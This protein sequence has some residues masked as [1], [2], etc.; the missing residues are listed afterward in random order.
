MNKTGLVYHEDYLYHKTGNLHAECPARLISIINH[1]KTIGFYDQLHPITPVEA[2]RFWLEQIHRSN[3]ISSVETACQNGLS[4]LDADTDISK[5]S[6]RVA[7]LA[8]GGTLAAI[9]KVMDGTIKN[10]FCAI[11]PPGHHATK[12]QAM[13]FCLFNNVAIAARYIQQKYNLSKILIVDWDVHH[14]NGTQDSFYHDPSVFYFSIHQWPH[15]PGTGH[16]L[17]SGYGLGIGYTLNIPLK[18]GADD[19]VY[20]EAFI[21]QLLPAAIKFAPDFILISAGFDAH[22][23]DPLSDM[24]LTEQ[25]F[26]SLTKIICD[27]AAQTCGGRLISILEGGYNLA[28][29]ASSV[30]FHIK[31]LLEG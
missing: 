17:E 14:G 30:E 6:Y 9:D 5:D 21:N 4:S 22:Q 26:S 31:A 23:E 2:D 19:N 12:N 13:G 15:Y 24:M 29:L 20:V 7:L 28:S 27:L 11:R 8:V 1:L 18:A 3:Y 10:A 16:Q 25:G